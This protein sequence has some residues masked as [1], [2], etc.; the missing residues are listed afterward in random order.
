[1][2]YVALN[3]NVYHVQQPCIALFLISGD[4][5]LATQPI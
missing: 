2:L 3:V 5:S 1:M 4:P